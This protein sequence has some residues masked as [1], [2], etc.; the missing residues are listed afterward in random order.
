MSPRPL[1]SVVVPCRNRAHYL[2]ST[3]DSILR[4]DYPAIECIVVDGASTD[5]TADVLHA[6]GERIRWLSEPDRGAFDAINRGWALARGEILA[7][8]NADDAWEPGAAAAAV[9]A[10]ERHPGAAAVYGGAIGVDAGGQIAWRFPA[11]AWDLER[12]ILECDHVI[13]QAAAFVRRGAVERAGGLYPAWTH[14]HELWLRIA[15]AGGEFVQLDATIARVRVS[16]GD[17]HHD[18]G[19]MIPAR[20]AMTRRIFRSPALPPALTGQERRALSN[21][22]VSALD[23]LSPLSPRDWGWTAHCIAGALR[24]DPA[25]AR[26]VLS[27][28]GRK[29]AARF[30]RLA[31][32]VDRRGG[33]AS[34][35]VPAQR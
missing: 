17:L 11:R 2:A 23:L 18:P 13:H 25:N 31:P 15:L 33:S 4:Q 35:A 5:G 24:T 1:V 10:L 28:A 34:V 7:W 19:V 14:D 30:P 21:V 29:A 22:Y 32:L 27:L 16:P 6:Y 3:L 20:L 26:A 8:L 9:A 12:A